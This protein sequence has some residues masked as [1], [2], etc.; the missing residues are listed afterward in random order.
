MSKN[1]RQKIKSEWWLFLVDIPPPSTLQTH[2][3]FYSRYSPPLPCP[4]SYLHIHNTH[5][6]IQPG[7]ATARYYIRKWRPHQELHLFS[8]TWCWMAWHATS[9]NWDRYVTVMN[10]PYPRKQSVRLIV[11]TA[12]DRVKKI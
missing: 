12:T 2:H 3:F 8:L 5:R 7:N 4:P 11:C 6:Q 9:R 10:I 1:R